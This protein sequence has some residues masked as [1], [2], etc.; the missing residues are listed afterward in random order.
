MGGFRGWVLAPC[1]AIAALI[2]AT[3]ASA[4]P[5]GATPPPAMATITLSLNR[6]SIGADGRDSA[7]LSI[8]ASVGGAPAS[9]VRARLSA[10]WSTPLSYGH[11]TFRPASIA[12]DAN[13]HGASAVTSTRSGSAVITV[14][15]A[16]RT[17]A[18]TASID[19]GLHRR[20]VVIFVNGASTSVTC[21]SPGDCADLTGSLDPIRS[22]LSS[23]GYAADDMPWFSYKGGKI[24]KTTH[25]W[26]PNASTCADTGQSLTK[27]TG[28]LR[29]MVRNVASATANSD[30]SLV[31]L[32]EG[33]ALAFQM[34]AAQ[35]TPL[36][37]GSRVVNV[38]TIDGPLGGLPAA[39]ITNLAQQAP[40]T[41]C[42]F[43]PKPTSAAS[44]MAAVWNITAP[45]QGPQQGDDATVLCN[46]IHFSGCTTAE[47]N[48]Q[49]V[50][51][52][53]DVNVETWG[54]SQDGVFNPAQCAIPG[55]WADATPSQV[56]A[57]AGGGMH[58]EGVA[59]VLNCTIGSHLAGVFNHATDIATTIGAQQQ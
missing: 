14:T 33:G 31:G 8:D 5:V 44:Q 43:I 15:I 49:L 35:T 10:A 53:P 46:V 40:S 18:G 54:S 1:A 13:G 58:A 51:S 9:G 59:P 50:A 12:L 29:T 32:S 20:S 41:A 55:S 22:A 6:T 45:N 3:S 7:S 37:K 56:V 36:A 26:I 25:A 34:L 19:L 39:D 42:A 23:E 28:L 30:I 27:S 52:R 48:A 4:A 16:T 21:T 17:I 47:T 38:I 24:D 57:G 2:V 11:L